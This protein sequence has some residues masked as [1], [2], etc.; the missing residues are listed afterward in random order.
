MSTYVLFKLY[1]ASR[2]SLHILGYFYRVS[3]TLSVPGSTRRGVGYRKKIHQ[4]LN[5]L[6]WLQ[7]RGEFLVLSVR[8]VNK[9]CVCVCVC[10]RNVLKY[11]LGHG[12]RYPERCPQNSAEVFF[13]CDP[14][15]FSQDAWSN[16]PHSCSNRACGNTRLPVQRAC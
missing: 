13:G 1:V 2:K 12:I 9:C 14:T 5:T 3:H 10:V 7:S 6:V 11:V 8:P 4:M 16:S 15:C